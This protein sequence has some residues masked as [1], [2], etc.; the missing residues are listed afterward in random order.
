MENNRATYAQSEEHW[1]PTS[2]LL[3]G[4]TQRYLLREQERLPVESF[5]SRLPTLEEYL[6]LLQNVAH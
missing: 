4:N 6:P 1:S 3:S 2:S 5:A